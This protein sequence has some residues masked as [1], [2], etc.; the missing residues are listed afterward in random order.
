MIDSKPLHCD[1]VHGLVANEKDVVN[2]IRLINTTGRNH[3]MLVED[4]IRAKSLFWTS[5]LIWTPRCSLVK[6]QR[7]QD[8]RESLRRPRHRQPQQADA[9][10]C[11]WRGESAKSR[12]AASPSQKINRTMLFVK[13]N[14]TDHSVCGKRC[15]YRGR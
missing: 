13:I 1:R 15:I 9:V 7:D 6:T 4:E 2:N 5:R 3:Y 11:R 14:F 12:H 10:R 8:G